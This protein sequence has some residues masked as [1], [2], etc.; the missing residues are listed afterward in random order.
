VQFAKVVSAEAACTGR[1]CR[2]RGC[3]GTSSGKKP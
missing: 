3:G 2:I 1:W